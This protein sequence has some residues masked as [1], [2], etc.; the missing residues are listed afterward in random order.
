M[1]TIDENVGA[2]GDLYQLRDPANSG[3]QRIIPF[4]E[5]YP[6]PLRQPLCAASDFA[7]TRFEHSYELPGSF[8]RVDHRAQS[9]NHVKDPG[10]ASLIEGMDVEPAANEV[11]D[12]VG[13]KIGECQDKIG[14]GLR[15]RILSMFAEMKAL[16]RGFSRRACGGR[17]T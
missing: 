7:Q 2:A 16:T 17:T 3:D 4:L 11:R 6:W 15:S 8:D 5:E 13:L 9:P 10:D 14:S 12:D 1:P